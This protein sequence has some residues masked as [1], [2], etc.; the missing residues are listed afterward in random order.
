[1]SYTA[2]CRTN[3]LLNTQQSCRGLLNYIS[4]PVILPGG[5]GD[6]LGGPEN[7]SPDFLQ[8]LVGRN[9][10]LKLL[11]PHLH[12][13]VLLHLSSYLIVYCYLESLSL[14]NEMLCFY[15]VVARVS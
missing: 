11:S 13:Q 1:M 4:H 12:F 3:L 14:S 2:A 15:F 5:P 9:M 10:F 7:C 8:E 6:K